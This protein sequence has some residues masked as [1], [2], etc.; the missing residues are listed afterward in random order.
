M[1]G[2]VLYVFGISRATTRAEWRRLHRDMRVSSKRAEKARQERID[3]LA[4]ADL[5]PCERMRL[6]NELK[7]TPIVGAML[8]FC[9]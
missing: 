2:E 7:N 3:L 1:R 8:S 4:S 9:R 5:P 6:V